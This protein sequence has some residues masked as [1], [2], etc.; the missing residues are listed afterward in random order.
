MFLHGPVSSMTL[1]AYAGDF[2]GRA[3]L[4]KWAAGTAMAL[5]SHGAVAEPYIQK[6]MSFGHLCPKRSLL[7]DA[8]QPIGTFVPAS[9]P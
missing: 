9:L 3:M 2:H 6:M 8:R 7:F 4:D 5:L 1:V